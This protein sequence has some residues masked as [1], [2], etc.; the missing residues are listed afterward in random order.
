MLERDSR[1]LL[2]ILHARLRAIQESLREQIAASD[3][4][5]QANQNTDD[6][7]RWQRFG[8]RVTERQIRKRSDRE[9]K[10]Q[11]EKNYR[12]QVI[13]NFL[14]LLAVLGGWFYATVAIIQSYEMRRATNATEETAEIGRKTLKE[15]AW[16][17]RQTMQRNK[18]QAEESR[19]QSAQSLQAT[20]DQFNL[21]QRPYIVLTPE[22]TKLE[23]STKAN[24]EQFDLK[25][26]ITAENTGNL[27]AYK[28]YWF[29]DFDP[30]PPIG[31]R[32]DAFKIAARDL[33]HFCE[34]KMHADHGTLPYAA[35]TVPPHSKYE[36][37]EDTA[38][39]TTAMIGVTTE[40]WKRSGMEVYFRGC[41]IYYSPA[42]KKTHQTG[43]LYQPLENKELYSPIR[44][45]DGIAD[46]YMKDYSGETYSD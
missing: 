39:S 37:L 30:I 25:Y 35:F 5:N 42:D 2:E 15:N 45:G 22:I 29:P 26:R 14:T 1:E 17:F 21:T 13:M 20:I 32:E 43:Y 31:P 8:G 16:Q 24:A 4:R 7:I 34:A 10:T 38:T 33:K 36:R 23:W 12:Q 46:V 9:A 27:P 11:A 28:V 40:K 18:E 41:F 44:F 6:E 3:E 19:R